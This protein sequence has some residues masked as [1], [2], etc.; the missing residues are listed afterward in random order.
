MAILRAGPF[1]I[2]S[3]SFLNEP[4]PATFAAPVNCASDGTSAN[5]PWR[6]RFST[7]SRDTPS[8]FS[9]I[10]GFPDVSGSDSSLG[11]F[12]G[13]ALW[14]Y[15]ATSSF[16]LTF[17]YEVIA[18]T[19]NGGYQSASFYV[20]TK[21]GDFILDNDSGF[22]ITATISGSVTLEFPASVVP[23]IILIVAQTEAKGG[24]SFSYSV[25]PA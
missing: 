18:N 12:S 11:S 8:V 7:I 24:G 17:T 13:S 16:S 20:R 4:V 15:Q 2:G 9:Y 23:T 22:G 1:S 3:D 14:Y 10:D 25:I 21:D 19:N 6:F 5:W